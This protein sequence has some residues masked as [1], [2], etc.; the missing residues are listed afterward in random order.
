MWN[1]IWKN[2]NYFK[3]NKKEKLKFYHILKNKNQNFRDKILNYIKDYERDLINLVNEYL[4][5]NS[6]IISHLKKDINIDLTEDTNFFDDVNSDTE[7]DNDNI[8]NIKNSTT[9]KKNII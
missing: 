4:V 9:T 8:I 7:S 5:K 2:F 6:N 1:N 3:K